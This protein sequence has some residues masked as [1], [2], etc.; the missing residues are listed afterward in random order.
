MGVVIVTAMVTA[1]LAAAAVI[2]VIRRWSRSRSC[3]RDK[4]EIIRGVELVTVAKANENAKLPLSAEHNWCYRVL[5]KN[6]LTNSSSAFV[7]TRNGIWLA[8][9]PSRT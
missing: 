2:A 8:P 4:I 5:S 9:S 1:G 7:H 6:S 3:N